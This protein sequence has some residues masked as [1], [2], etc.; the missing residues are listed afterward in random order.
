MFF[1]V[2]AVS[3]ASH[4]SSHVKLLGLEDVLWIA[5][6]VEVDRSENG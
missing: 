6:Q 1:I 4:I 3:V 2:H 5:Q